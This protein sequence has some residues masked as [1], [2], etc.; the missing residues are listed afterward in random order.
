MLNQITIESVLPSLYSSVV[1]CSGRAISS[2]LSLYHAIHWQYEYYGTVE[3]FAIEWNF[4]WTKCKGHLLMR[5]E[6]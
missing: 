2:T 5:V 6:Y 3:R 4:Q 1:D